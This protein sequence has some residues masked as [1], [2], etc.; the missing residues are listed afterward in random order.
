MDR[1]E[2]ERELLGYEEG[3][4][5]SERHI[6]SHRLLSI[7]L[8]VLFFMVI[9]LEALK[10]TVVVQK[11][12]DFKT[13]GVVTSC[14]VVQ[15]FLFVT[16]SYRI[17][18][19]VLRRK[20]VLGRVCMVYLIQIFMFATLYL[21]FYLLMHNNADGDETRLTLRSNQ[22]FSF[23]AQMLYEGDHSV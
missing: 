10:G 2:L 3:T 6:K 9:F 16:G 5:C 11:S 1:V 4:S 8:V 18:Y 22:A 21:L 17:V 13:I 7:S 15:T 12:S 14:L 23:H 19:A 20:V